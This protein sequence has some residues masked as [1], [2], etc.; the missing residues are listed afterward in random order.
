MFRE[1]AVWVEK[2]LQK[3]K[4]LPANKQAA[5]LGAST[6]VFRQ[7][8][9]PHIHSH[10]VQPLIDAGWQVLHIDIKKEDGVDLIADVTEDLFAE[11]FENRFGLTVCTNMLEHV[12]DIAKVAGNIFKATMHGGYILITVPYKYKKHLDPIDN[13]FRPA[14]GEIAM[15]FRKGTA[16]I[17]DSKIIIIKDK[18]YYTIKKSR[19]PFWGYRELIGYYLGRYH[20]VS[21]I[22]LKINKEG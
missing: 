19:F 2:A 8:V 11:R 4:P 14:P 17:I 7:Q 16:E 21:G 3:I 1:E 10:V 5:N 22:L 15:L 9:Q 20:K 6:A 12:Q 18:A 13:M